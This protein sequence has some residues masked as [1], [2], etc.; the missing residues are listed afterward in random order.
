MHRAVIEEGIGKGIVPVGGVKLE[1][2]FERP[3]GILEKPVLTAP[4][5]ANALLEAV[6]TVVGPVHHVEKLGMC[7]FISVGGL[8]VK[9][10]GNVEHK[11]VEGAAAGAFGGDHISG[12]PVA[13][14]GY[15]VEGIEAAAAFAAPRFKIKVFLAIGMSTRRIL[16]EVRGR[17]DLASFLLFLS[18]VEWPH[19]IN[20][21][22]LEP[23][24]A[25]VTATEALN[26]RVCLKCGSTIGAG[27]ATVIFGVVGGTGHGRVCV[28]DAAVAAHFEPTMPCSKDTD[29][30][31]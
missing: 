21:F 2:L 8:L 4:G 30:P 11:T 23:D 22:P 29:F 9:E 24:P 1:H 3:D 6:V 27:I 5:G 12:L 10:E 20:A 28:T 31:P 18:P 25:A 17:H 7:V 26:V 15:V 19:A 13:V 16:S 14:A